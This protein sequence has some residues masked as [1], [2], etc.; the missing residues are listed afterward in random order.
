M[1]TFVYKAKKNSSETVTGTIK[2]LNR[3]EAIELINQLGLLP[4]SVDPEKGEIAES[5]SKIA[6]IKNKE[7]YLF[8][9]QLANLL[10]SSVSLI[11]ALSIIGDQT[12]H[13]Y[14]KKI[15]TDICWE[16]KNGKSFSESLSAYPDI[17]STLYLTMIRAGEESG[18]LHGMLE[19]IAKYQRSQ[20]EIYSKV[21]LALAYPLFMLI[22]GVGTIYF[23]LSVVFP[24]MAGLFDNLGDNL[25]LA[26]SILLSI[27]Q[28]ITQRWYFI[29]L[30]IFVSGFIISRW[31]IS[32]KGK[33][34][35]SRLILNT[36][37]F[38]ELVLKVDLARFCRTMVMLNHSGVSLLRALQISIPLI[39]N[40][41]IRDKFSKAKEQL[42][43][44]ES[45][46]ESLKDFTYIPKMMTHLITIGEEAGNLD[47]VLTEIADTFEQETDEKIKIMTTL[48]EPLMILIIGTVI[49]FIVFAMLLPIFQADIFAQ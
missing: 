18:N 37:L 46:G 24:K 16:V 47:G 5:S 38:G 28:A 34:M 49:G 11:K 48:L 2:A 32:E 12:T 13:P 31:A 39:G 8:S 19:S 40:Q 17:F 44:G 4:V 35:L 3:D 20:E 22:V 21:R 15:V 42:E 41:L 36:P 29:V 14:F 45:L 26:T 43:G 25:P 9:R 6:R 33:A 27:S 30:V 7:L 23:V 1:T 10:K